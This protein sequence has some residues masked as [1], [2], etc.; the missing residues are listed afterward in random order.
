MAAV[1]KALPDANHLGTNRA[2]LIQAVVVRADFS[3]ALQDDE[4][5]PD[6]ASNHKV[7]PKSTPSA[8][9]AL[10]TNVKSMG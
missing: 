2:E 6:A 7:P 5:A 1:H 9:Q 4:C 3:R 10:T 8:A